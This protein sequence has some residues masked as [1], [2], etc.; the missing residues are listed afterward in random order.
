MDT[1]KPFLML[2]C[3]AFVVGFMGYLAA[4]RMAS[5]GTPAPES[6]AVA[7]DAGQ[8]PAS[9]PAPAAEDDDFS[10]GKAI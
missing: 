3:V 10:A 9:A 6:Y 5:T 4:Y 8:Q 7:A 1:L 2:A